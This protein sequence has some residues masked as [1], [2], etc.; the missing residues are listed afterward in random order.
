[1]TL[2][3]SYFAVLGFLRC[4]GFPSLN[5][6]TFSVPNIEAPGETPTFFQNRERTVD[7][8]GSVPF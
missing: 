4:G 8:D 7:G 6:S 1:M 2:I 5:R 3:V